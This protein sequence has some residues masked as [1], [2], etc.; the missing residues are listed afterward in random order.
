MFISVF[1]IKNSVKQLKQFI[2]FWNGWCMR[3]VW[4]TGDDLKGAL[5]VWRA[6][7]TGRLESSLVLTSILWM[8][9]SVSW[10]QINMGTPAWNWSPRCHICHKA[11]QEVIGQDTGRKSVFFCEETRASIY[12][13]MHLSV[14]VVVGNFWPACMLIPAAPCFLFSDLL[15]FIPR[16]F[17]A[18]LDCLLL[19]LSSCTRAGG[20]FPN[21]PAKSFSKMK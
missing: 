4:D 10:W 20:A 13:L 21:H 2:L 8:G 14:Y 11:N 1:Y 16:S 6:C 12:L 9:A 18:R 7:H 3:A 19:P 5:L 17:A 15:I